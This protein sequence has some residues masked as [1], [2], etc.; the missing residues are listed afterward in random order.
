MIDFDCNLSVND[1][2]TI[3]L[4]FNTHHLSNNMNTTTPKEN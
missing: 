4:D 3:L 1:A 2:E